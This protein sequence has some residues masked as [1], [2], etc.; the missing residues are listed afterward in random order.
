[1]NQVK[2]LVLSLTLLLLVSCTRQQSMEMPAPTAL[3]TPVAGKITVLDLM[4]PVAPAGM[5][6]G[7]IYFT[8]QNGTD[9]PLHLQG[10]TADVAAA[11]SFHETI[12]DQGVIRMIAQPDGFVVAAGESLVLA[13]G[14]K[15]LML[16]KLRTPLVAGEQ[17]TLT[18]TFA[19]AAPL[20]LTV[21]V[22]DH[23]DAPMDHSKMD[24]SK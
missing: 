6:N 20:T 23:G 2:R 11:L 12:D 18:L 3:P 13:P 9:Q 24:H 22:M 10:A 17:F 5:S 19:D 8:L 16:E 14:S 15:H 4:A 1:M 7:S 21:P